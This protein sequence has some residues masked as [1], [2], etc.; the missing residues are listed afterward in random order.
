MEQ[1]TSEKLLRDLKVVVED[2]EA[3]LAA[4]AGQTGEKIEQLR[5]RAKESL[6]AARQRLQETGSEIQSRARA[7][8]KTTDDYV[9]DNP[10]TAIAIAAGIGFLMG[11]LSNRR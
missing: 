7:A 9:H 8:A 11:S 6:A 10:W 3:L 2:A 1:V 5:N 4:T